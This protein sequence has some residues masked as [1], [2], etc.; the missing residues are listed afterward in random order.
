LLVVS[1]SPI[2]IP[3]NNPINQRWYQK[4]RLS[5]Y[6]TG[7][8]FRRRAVVHREVAEREEASRGVRA[9]E[10]AA[11][12]AMHFERSGDIPR[13]GMYLQQAAENA[14]S[15]SAFSEA[16]TH[17]QRALALLE[18]EPAGRERTEREIKLWI[19]LGASAMAV[20]G[21]GTQEA[22]RAYSR[23]RKLCNELGESPVLF[24]ALWGLWL[25]YWGRGPLSAAHELAQDLLGLAHERFW[26][27]E[28][29]RLRGELQILHD[30]QHA[31]R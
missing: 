20:R 1:E 16:R 13:A 7:F 22:E 25:F 28:L 4:S 21:W 6:V 19:G 10:I 17:F 24:P 11:E 30:P 8:S 9:C 27:P 31:C 18:I 14:R 5:D 12:L 23:A 26:E 15:R 3:D 2:L 29:L